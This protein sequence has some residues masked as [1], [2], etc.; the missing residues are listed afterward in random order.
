M[1][2]LTGTFETSGALPPG[3]ASAMSAE[4]SVRFRSDSPLVGSGS[5]LTAAAR[6]G[7]VGSV[8]RELESASAVEVKHEIKHRAS[9]FLGKANAP[10]PRASAAARVAPK[11]QYAFRLPPIAVAPEVFE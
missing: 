7:R 9:V 10:M 3:P 5:T 8:R 2:A 1:L 11:N 6:R 4:P